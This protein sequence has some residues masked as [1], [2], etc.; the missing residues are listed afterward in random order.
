[1]NHVRGVPHHLQI[2]G[3]IERWHETLKSRILLEIYDL[4][5]DLRRRFDY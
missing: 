3:K 1:M 4:P 5:S 2:H